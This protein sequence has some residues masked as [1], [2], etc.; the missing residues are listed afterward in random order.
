MFLDKQG[1]IRTSKK[2]ANKQINNISPLS[3]KPKKE[4]VRPEKELN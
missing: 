1:N 3:P 4:N 2:E